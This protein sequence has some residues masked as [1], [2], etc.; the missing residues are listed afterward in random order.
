MHKFSIISSVFF[1]F[2]STS[3]ASYTEWHEE[4]KTKYKMTAEEIDQHSHSIKS[5]QDWEIFKS[6]QFTIQPRYNTTQAII[7]AAERK[8]ALLRNELT[9]SEQRFHGVLGQIS[10]LFPAAK[11]HPSK[12]D[13][14]SYKKAIMATILTRIGVDLK[15]DK[16]EADVYNLVESPIADEQSRRKKCS[17]HLH[18]HRVLIFKQMTVVDTDQKQDPPT[19]KLIKMQRFE[20]V[21]TVIAKGVLCDLCNS[22]IRQGLNGPYLT[23]GKKVWDNYTS[24]MEKLKEHASFFKDIEN[25]LVVWL[26][27]SFDKNSKIKSDNYSDFMGY[28]G[29]TIRSNEGAPIVVMERS[30][31]FSE[32]AAKF[33]LTNQAI[34][35]AEFYLR[36][37][38]SDDFIE[39]L[40]LTGQVRQ[41]SWLNILSIVKWYMNNNDLS[42]GIYDFSH[43]ELLRLAID[44]CLDIYFPKKI[45]EV[46]EQMKTI[47]GHTEEPDQKHSVDMLQPEFILGLRGMMAELTTNC[48]NIQKALNN[49][50]DQLDELEKKVAE[51]ANSGMDL[52]CNLICVEILLGDHL[53]RSYD[54][55]NPRFLELVDNE[56]KVIYFKIF[57]LQERFITN[58]STLLREIKSNINK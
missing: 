15:T 29:Q 32:L 43:P 10:E 36:G 16:E 35:I 19:T 34:L 51:T 1:C 4:A 33:F 3:Q 38:T 22:L 13:F 2:I 50:A 39:L 9:L 24:C 53:L 18:N 31:Q 23:T 12:Q 52:L 54:P 30:S 26:Y 42:H 57:D 17:Q 8:L 46:L 27:N 37:F 20:D 58:F 44:R 21:F 45:D 56:D 40:S 7:D 41:C 28:W 14:D 6:A 48:S 55:D 11:H 49:K 5:S 47:L 25:E